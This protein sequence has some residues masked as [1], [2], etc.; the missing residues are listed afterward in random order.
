MTVGIDKRRGK[1]RDQFER[2][3]R[4]SRMVVKW[5]GAFSRAIPGKATAAHI[6]IGP[7][8]TR[9]VTNQFSKRLGTRTH[10]AD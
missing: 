3:R 8:S 9:L 1:G 5:E 10:S 2:V 4:C 7:G 6:H